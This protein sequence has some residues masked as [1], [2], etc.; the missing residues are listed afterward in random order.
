MRPDPITSYNTC[1]FELNEGQMFEGFHTTL[2]LAVSANKVI[3]ANSLLVVQNTVKRGRETRQVGN[4]NTSGS[5]TLLIT[6]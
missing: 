5:I 1:F 6:C 3:I 4:I 2:G